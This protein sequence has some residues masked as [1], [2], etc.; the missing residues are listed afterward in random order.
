MHQDPA[1]NAR[2]DTPDAPIDRFVRYFVLIV[3]TVPICYA[4]VEKFV[5][6]W[7]LEGP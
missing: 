6:N 4:F 5:S 2:R 3:I 1:S 7:F